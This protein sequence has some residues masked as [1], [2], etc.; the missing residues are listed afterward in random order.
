M[1][2]SDEVKL[3]K[4]IDFLDLVSEIGQA[5]DIL[6]VGIDTIHG[7][8]LQNEIERGLQGVE[9]IK[10]VVS[11][12]NDK[13]LLDWSETSLMVK[14]S[15]EKPSLQ[16]KLLDSAIEDGDTRGYEIVKKFFDQR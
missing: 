9:M 14:G 15:L 6:L 16:Q 12:C 7:L 10:E 3:Q 13:L 5:L 2:A 1:E 4:C 8:L 11:S